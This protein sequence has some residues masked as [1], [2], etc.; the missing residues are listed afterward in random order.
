MIAVHRDGRVEDPA[1]D[2]LDRQTDAGLSRGQQLEPWV[3]NLYQIAIGRLDLSRIRGLTLAGGSVPPGSEQ[4]GTIGIEEFLPV[5]VNS[6]ETFWLGIEVILAPRLSLETSRM[7]QRHPRLSHGLT[8]LRNE[9]DLASLPEHWQPDTREACW[10][11]WI[12]AR[13]KL[14]GSQA[15]LAEVLIR[16]LQDSLES[17]VNSGTDWLG[18]LACGEKLAASGWEPLQ[19]LVAIPGRDGNPFLVSLLTQ[20][21][22]HFLQTTLIESESTEGSDSIDQ[23]DFRSACRLLAEERLPIESV[24]APLRPDSKKTGEQQLAIL[25]QAVAESPRN[26][27]LLVQRGQH[28]LTQCRLDDALIDFALAVQLQAGNLSA[29]MGRAEI[30]FR[31]NHPERVAADCSLILGW[32]PYHIPA[33]VLRGRAYLE[34]ERL[35]PARLDF[36]RALGIDPHHWLAILGRAILLGRSG[37]NLLAIQELDRAVECCPSGNADLLATRAR[38]RF[39]LNDSNGAKKDYDTALQLDPGRTDLWVERGRLRLRQGAIKGAIVDFGEAITRE[40]GRSDLWIERARG[41]AYCGHLHRAIAD[42]DEAIKLRPDLAGTWRYRGELRA[43]LGDPVSAQRDLDQAVSVEPKDAE[44]RITRADFLFRRGLLAEALVDYDTAIAKAPQNARGWAGRAQVHRCRHQI[45]NALTDGRMAARLDP[46][47]LPGVCGY[48]AEIFA[49]QGNL[50]EALAYYQI[51][52]Q[53][54]PTDLNS[55]AGKEKVEKE[56]ENHPDRIGQSIA[57]PGKAL[58]QEEFVPR[59]QPGQRRKLNRT[60]SGQ[61]ATADDTVVVVS[62]ADTLVETKALAPGPAAPPSSPEAQIEEILLEST[63]EKQDCKPPQTTEVVSSQ[64]GETAEKSPSE[65]E[66]TIPTEGDWDQEE[67]QPVPQERGPIAARMRREQQMAQVLERALE[68]SEKNESD[69]YKLIQPPRPVLATPPERRKTQKPVS[70]EE[71]ED[72]ES[73]RRPLLI[74]GIVLLLLTALIGGYRLW[75]M[76]PNLEAEQIWKEFDRD[77]KKVLEQYNGRFVRLT[78]AV[79]LEDV[80]EE[81]RTVFARRENGSWAIQFKIPAADSSKFKDGDQVTIRGRLAGRLGTDPGSDLLI[82]NTSL[83][84]VGPGQA[85]EKSGSPGK[86]E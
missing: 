79:Q 75:T 3:I 29:L 11:S 49:A 51:A 39:L 64:G 43:L 62:Q 86:E 74:G 77:P 27:D 76:E 59:H 65:K 38:I 70:R 15:T 32:D 17:P 85:G 35:D 41:W 12:S 42:C 31:R 40:P 34:L 72:E 47:F 19:N 63:S 24:V 6:F 23:Y 20:L 21:L 56:L 2:R 7:L 71:L 30:N 61:Q 10:K 68:W 14:E 8:A 33:L 1:I 50:E 5:V 78:G 22:Q 84:K 60:T 48:Q 13:R 26:P 25:D 18:W 58:G 4:T 83:I 82:S 9:I 80:D 81:V 53:L 66:E 52:L 73:P 37:E 57:K 36:E 46:R 55:L 44:S 54:D 69:K 16:F 45:E 67:F 28:L